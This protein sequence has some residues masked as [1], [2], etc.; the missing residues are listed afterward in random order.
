MFKLKVVI[1]L[2]IVLLLPNCKNNES[3]TDK[4]KP[5]INLIIK[6][7]EAE[8]WQIVV[9]G[10][11]YASEEYNINLVAQGPVSEA[12]LSRQISILENAI[13]SNPAAIIIA[14]LSGDA[15]VPSMEKAYEKKIPLIIIDSKANTDK[16]VSFLASDNYK[17]GE[18]AADCMAEALT[19]RYGAAEGKV[20]GLI[21]LSGALSLENRKEGFLNRVNEK[22]PG[23][24]VVD[25]RDAQGQSGTSLNIVQDYLTT[26]KDLRGIFASN[27]QTGNET[28]RALDISQKKD[29]GVVV[30]DSGE[31]ELWGLENGYVDF[32]IVQQPWEMGYL[33]VENAKKAIDGEKVDNY[34]D[35]GVKAITQ[36]MLISGEAK[37][38]LNPEEFHRKLSK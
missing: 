12:D 16:Y 24:E 2:G 7:S 21:F 15:L 19:K 26:Y 29:L 35:T 9:D 1:L 38:F 17:L 14:P 37:E 23:I 3:G 33:G 27:F 28:V 6:A 13:A 18:L 32:M 34:Y 10:A 25:Y 30:V 20:A 22:Y 5:K 8:F 11:K 4:E 31:N 36:K